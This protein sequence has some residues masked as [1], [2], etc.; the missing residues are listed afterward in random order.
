VGGLTLY[1]VHCAIYAQ[2][3]RVAA[4]LTELAGIGGSNAGDWSGKTSPEESMPL[5]D[6]QYALVGS[7]NIDTRSLRLNFELNVEIYDSRVVDDLSRHFE[8]VRAR[9]SAVTLQ[10]VDSR[11]L[12]T[13]LIDGVAW[14]FSPYL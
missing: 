10:D 6:D 14:L 4:Q 7:A 13:R 3:T 8:A 1:L 11:K 12:A 2:Y 5:V 9:S